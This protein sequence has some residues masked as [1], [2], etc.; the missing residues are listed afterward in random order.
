MNLNKKYFLFRK[1][2]KT[3]VAADANY[4][5]SL[6]GFSVHTVRGWFRDE[7]IIIDRYD[8]SGF[9]LTKGAEYVKSNRGCNNPGFGKPN[10]KYNW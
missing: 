3:I 1:G 9:I 4:I 6:I 10:K 2:E 5:A 7:V 8:K